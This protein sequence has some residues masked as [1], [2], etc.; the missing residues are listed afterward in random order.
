[1]ME[2]GF[3]EV[4]ALHGGSLL[5]GGII[6]RTELKVFQPFMRFEVSG[7]GIILGLAATPEPKAVPL[8]NKSRLAGSASI[9]IYRLVLIWTGRGQNWR[10]FRAAARVP[11]SGK[12][13]ANRRD[14]HWH[15]RFQVRELLVLRAARQVP[16]RAWRC[17]DH[18]PK[19]PISP[20]A[21]VAVSL[22]K[23]VKPFV[24][25]EAPIEQ[26]EADDKKSS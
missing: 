15:H 19:A 9:T 10:Y 21:S 13:G 20:E 5:E 23:V 8:K 1:M 12:G 6:P 24:P 25:P 2:Q 7:K 22:K 17:A 26:E 3:E 4:C 16:E 18:G 11:P 14:R